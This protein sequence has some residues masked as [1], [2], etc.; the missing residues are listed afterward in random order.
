M[1]ATVE[2]TTTCPK[3]GTP[4]PM[5]VQFHMSSDG[6]NPVQAVGLSCPGCGHGSNGEWSV[7]VTPAE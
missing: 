1:T 2:T 6:E 3:C 4:P 7:P 5:N